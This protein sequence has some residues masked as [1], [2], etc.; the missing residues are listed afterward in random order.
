MEKLILGLLL[1][2]IWPTLLVFSVTERI[3]I[4]YGL[5]SPNIVIFSA[6]LCI[7]IQYHYVKL[8]IYIIMAVSG[9][10]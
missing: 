2:C 5:K 7:I 9:A 10:L 6:I 8:L 3:F 4:K 1:L